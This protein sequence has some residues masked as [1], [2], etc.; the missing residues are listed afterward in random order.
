MM[1]RK[2]L[3]RAAALM[4]AFAPTIAMTSDAPSLKE[5]MQGLRND[6]VEIS[7]GLLMGDFEQVARGAIAISEHPQIPEA[8]IQLVAEELGA[9]MA[10]FKQFDT[11]V[12]DLSL[13]IHA[14]AK[15][16]DH[17]TAVSAFQRLTDG[18]FAC[19]DTYKER[20]ASVLK[21]TG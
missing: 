20:V 13:D 17:R 9:E 12:H 4:L 10:A 6:L 18:C 3:I 11:R 19:H 15:A 16:H 8:Q 21:D 14:A 2:R 5:I 7:D 1:N